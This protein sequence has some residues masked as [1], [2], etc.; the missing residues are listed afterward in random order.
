MAGKARRGTARQAWHGEEG[1]GVEGCG[2][3]RHGRQNMAKVQA[4]F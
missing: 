1:H 4:I 2:T 3:A